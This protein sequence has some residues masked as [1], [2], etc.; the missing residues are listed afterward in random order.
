MMR[1]EGQSVTV[2]SNRVTR[3][4]GLSRARHGTGVLLSVVVG[5]AT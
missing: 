4:Q 5:Y 2:S 1:R 3:V